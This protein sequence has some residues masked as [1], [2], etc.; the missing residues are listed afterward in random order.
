MDLSV[1]PCWG[2]K[3]SLLYFTGTEETQSCE[4]SPDLFTEYVQNNCFTSFGG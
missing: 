4:M 1:K 2:R 3:T